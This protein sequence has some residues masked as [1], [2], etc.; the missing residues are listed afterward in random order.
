MAVL[1]DWVPAVGAAC[2]NLPRIVHKRRAVLNTCYFC[3]ELRGLQGRLPRYG[4][5]GAERTF[6]IVTQLPDSLYS[7]LVM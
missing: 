6:S 4:G 5:V 7:T 1:G 3:S 2:A